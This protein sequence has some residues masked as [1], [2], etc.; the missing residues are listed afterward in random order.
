MS[1]ETLLVT[2]DFDLDQLRFAERELAFFPGVEA[3][4]QRAHPL[5]PPFLQLQRHPGA[6]RFVRSSAVEDHI[7]VARDLRM[8]GFDLFGRHA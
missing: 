6:S 2:G 4:G 7:D 3:S 8:L 5:D 1:E